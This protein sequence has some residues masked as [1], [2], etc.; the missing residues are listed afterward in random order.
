M[1]LLLLG[2]LALSSCSLFGPD[3]ERTDLEA[4]RQRWASAR[5]ESYT[6]TF[7]R[8][9]ECWPALPARIVVE[10]DTVRAVLDPAT[11]EPLRIPPMDTLALAA[12]PDA[13]PTVEA[14]FDVIERA[15]RE[16]ADRLQVTYDARLGHPT[17]IEIDY[18]EDAADDE[19]TYTLEAFVGLRGVGSVID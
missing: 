12:Y 7:T 19:V 4:A 6:F 18:R 9:C 1:R 17:Q 14:L 5:F 13:Y 16:K 15:A 3:D 8:S 10:R 11:G 2:C